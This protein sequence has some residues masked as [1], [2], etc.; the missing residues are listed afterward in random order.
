MLGSFS[1]ACLLLTAI[2][3]PTDPSS[4]K[5]GDWPMWGGSPDRNMVSSE[6]GIP[7]TWDLRA[8]RNIK[9]VAPL[10]TT[11]Y[12]NPVIA[13]GRIYVGTNNGLYQFSLNTL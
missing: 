13:D 7:S 4:K 8:K 6:T 10:G 2:L 5:T 12:G 11:T 9:W 3:A 1:L